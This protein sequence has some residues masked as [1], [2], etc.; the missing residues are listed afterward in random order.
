MT[1]LQLCNTLEHNMITNMTDCFMDNGYYPPNIRKP[2]WDNHF[3]VT[4]A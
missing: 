1:Y 2:V 4:G 3:A